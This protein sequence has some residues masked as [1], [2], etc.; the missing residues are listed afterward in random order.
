M[1]KIKCPKCGEVFT[2]DED[3]Y[4][5]IV[6]QIKN[7]EFE[8]EI[9]RREKELSEKNKLD[10]EDLAHHMGISMSEI[11]NYDFNSAYIQIQRICFSSYYNQ[12][13]KNPWI[14]NEL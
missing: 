13:Y 6:S 12:Y 8:K 4:A 2:I 5:N 7:D 9:S 1:N 11:K 14:E 3:S 10:I